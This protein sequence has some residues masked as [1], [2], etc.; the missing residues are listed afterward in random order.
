MHVKVG[1]DQGRFDKLAFPGT[2]AMEQSESH[3]HRRR[4]AR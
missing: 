3:S 2:L 1:V 4:D